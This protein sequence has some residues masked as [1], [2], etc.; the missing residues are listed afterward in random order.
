MMNKKRVTQQPVNRAVKSFLSLA[1]AIAGSA[2]EKRHVIRALWPH[3]TVRSRVALITSGTAY[4]APII[5]Q[6]RAHHSI[7]QG[8]TQYVRTC[9]RSSLAETAAERTLHR[10]LSRGA[11]SPL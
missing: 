5:A 4:L 2:L 9:K 3:G 8:V 6:D 1:R 10:Q 11:T 7:G